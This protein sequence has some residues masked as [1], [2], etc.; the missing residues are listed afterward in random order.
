MASSMAFVYLASL[1]RIASSPSEIGKPQNK[2]R[3]RKKFGKSFLIS[4]TAFL[5]CLS[6]NKSSET[7]NELKTA[8]P[9]IS[10][11]S[12]TI[13]YQNVLFSMFDSYIIFMNSYDLK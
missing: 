2:K 10:L 5:A 8:A 7:I 6:R 1:I 13:M 11:S 3:I 12:K 4:F 9:I